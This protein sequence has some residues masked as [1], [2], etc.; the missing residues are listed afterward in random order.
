MEYKECCKATRKNVF[1]IIFLIITNVKMKKIGLITL[2][3]DNYG[4]ILQCFSTKRFV[5]SLNVECQVLDLESH[6][7]QIPFFK[8]IL[9]KFKTLMRMIAY[10]SLAKLVLFKKKAPTCVSQKTLTCMDS[11]VTSYITP[12]FINFDKL[13]SP[14]W[15]N[16]F[17][18]FV[19]GSDQ[20][21]KIENV[22]NSFRFLDFAPVSKRAT[23]AVSFGT[24]DFPSHSKSMAKKMLK[25]FDFISVREETGEKIVRKYSSARTLR[26]ADPSFIYNADEWRSISKST[27]LIHRKYILAHFL[28]EPSN[29]AVQSLIWLS[30]KMNLD[31]LVLGYNHIVLKNLKGLFFVD[32]G[33]WE[34]VSFIDRA[35][36]VLTDSFHSSL[37]SINFNKKFFVFERM[38]SFSK[39]SCRITDLLNRFGI[40][41]RLINNS[42]DLEGLYMHCL[43]DHVHQLFEEERAMIRSYI[44]KLVGIVNS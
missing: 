42:S 27:A 23:L 43:P 11:Y 28:N 41:N 39:Q 20:I 26:L 30:N 6:E 13:K 7:R 22:V 8:K 4:S 21:W 29:V 10:P 9:R 5:E 25:G 16:E 33:P 18:C 44:E 24:S 3:K 37:F 32:G 17:D 38:Y 14:A 35:E 31:V 34:Y 12:K 36:Y 1:R 19:V 15:L 2:Y 40:R